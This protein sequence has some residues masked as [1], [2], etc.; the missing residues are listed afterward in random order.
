MRG[1]FLSLLVCGL[2]FN[3]FGDSIQQLRS[4]LQQQKYSRAATTGLAL[5][6]QNPDDLQALFLTAQAF[7]KNQQPEQAIRHYQRMLE[8]DPS[9]PEPLNNLAAIYQQQGDHQ[10]AIELLTASI[11]THPAYATAWQNLSKLYRG[12]ASDAYRRALSEQEDIRSSIQQ[13][14]LTELDSLHDLPVPV[15]DN[16]IASSSAPAMYG[17]PSTAATD[18]TPP[19]SLVEVIEH[20]T[21]PAPAS[22]PPAV[23]LPATG[24]Q[25]TARPEPVVAVITPAPTVVEAPPATPETT[26][27]G[28]PSEALL[29]ST[30]EKW[31]RAWDQKDFDTYINA[32]TDDYRGRRANHAAWVKFRRSRVLRPGDIRV[33]LSNI[34]VHSRSADRAVIDFHQAY[35]SPNYRD[36]VA[37]RVV[38]VND[39]GIWKIARESTLAVL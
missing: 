19:P 15:A 28:L 21:I 38:L 34:R 6:R 18:R 24:P 32:Y 4:E 8:I 31:A 39:R 25:P 20:E 14:Q 35:S 29:Q 2:S 11:N 27:P 22:E 26:A 17:Q 9:L 3:A 10:K 23:P 16:Q 36:K 7:H 1:L 30:I 12:L 5:L 33:T 37:K 13:L